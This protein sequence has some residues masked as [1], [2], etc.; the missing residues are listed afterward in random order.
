MTHKRRRRRSPSSEEPPAVHCGGGSA[1]GQAAPAPMPP[2]PVSA[3]APRAAPPAYF[4]A[5]LGM[6]MTDEEMRRLKEQACASDEARADDAQ[7]DAA[8]DTRED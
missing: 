7:L 4:E 1:L 5:P 2:A 6:P 8:E 3:P